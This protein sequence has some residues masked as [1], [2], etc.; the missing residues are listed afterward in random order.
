M[1]Q[2]ALAA[3]TCSRPRNTWLLAAGALV[4]MRSTAYAYLDPGTGGLLL[5]LLLGGVAGLAVILKL[6]WQKVTG[7]FKRNA[8]ESPDSDNRHQRAGQP[9][10]TRK[11]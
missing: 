9:Q 4:A 3:R 11:E 7:L 5:Q 8:P 6:Y 1:K 2:A 10:D